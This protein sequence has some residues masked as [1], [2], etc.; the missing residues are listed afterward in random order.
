M[1]QAADGLFLDLTDAFAREVELLADLFERHFRT[2][3]A[4]EIFDDVAFA[5]GERLQRPIDFGRE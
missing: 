5:L 2:A 3:D 1:A 4:E